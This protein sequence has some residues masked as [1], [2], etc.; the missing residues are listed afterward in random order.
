MDLSLI[1]RDRSENSMDF[2]GILKGSSGTFRDFQGPFRN[3]Q[4][5]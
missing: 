3:L 2:S 5:F 4:G 1:F